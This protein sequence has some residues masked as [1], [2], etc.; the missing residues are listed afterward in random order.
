MSD[1]YFTVQSASSSNN[2]LQHL[3]KNVLKRHELFSVKV[4]KIS[5]THMNQLAEIYQSS[6]FHPVIFIL[7]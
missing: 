1:G 5:I 6:K 2:S 3:K 7:R 4:I